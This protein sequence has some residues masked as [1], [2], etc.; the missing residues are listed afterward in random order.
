MLQDGGID[1]R[2]RPAETLRQYAAFHADPLDPASL[3]GELGLDAVASTPYRRLSGGERQRLGFALA[4]VGR[5][6]VLLLD[7]PTA[8]LDPEGRA[9]VRARIT[10]ERER[11]TAVLVTTHELADAERVADRVVIVA[12]G[13]VVSE[14]TPAELASRRAP[15]LRFSL[16]RRLGAR[17]LA[18][19]A[20]ALGSTVLDDDGQY[21]IDGATPSPRMVA[22]L[23]GWCE[24]A[25]VLITASGTT[26]RTLEEAYLALIEAGGASDAPAPTPEPGP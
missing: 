3:L 2:A 25:G 6:E 9:I 7:E 26:D 20:A 10:A 14:G 4:L 24:A 12:A 17:E 1:V 21:V 8:G 15:R 19:L 22:A 5:P 16:D 11:G 13:R 23:A 18:A